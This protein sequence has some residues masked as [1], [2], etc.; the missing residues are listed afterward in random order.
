M[1]FSLLSNVSTAAAALVKALSFP[2]I[3]FRVTT[4]LSIGAVFRTK[5]RCGH[6]Q[7]AR[8]GAQSNRP[9]LNQT[10]LS[11]EATDIFIITNELFL[12]VLPSRTE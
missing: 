4:N 1:I 10:P 5:P 12:F 7:P 3:A 6:M 11:S 8:G 2:A 9:L